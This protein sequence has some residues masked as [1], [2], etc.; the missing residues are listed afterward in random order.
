MGVAPS[1]CELQAALEADFQGQLA[2]KVCLPGTSY[3][4]GSHAVCEPSENSAAKLGLPCEPLVVQLVANR[5]HLL[6]LGPERGACGSELAGAQAAG[7]GSP[8][9]LAQFLA[10]LD[11]V[12]LLSPIHFISELPAP[13]WL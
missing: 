2:Y 12:S 8:A 11:Q 7:T 1:V 3:A 9:A 10:E 4:V 5:G 6:P 13:V